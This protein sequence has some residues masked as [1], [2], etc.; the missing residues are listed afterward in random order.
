ML[1]LKS[2]MKVLMLL[3]VVGE[4]PWRRESDSEDRVS[5]KNLVWSVYDYD[6]FFS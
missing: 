4:W 6:V 5:K 1:K 3:V 2:M